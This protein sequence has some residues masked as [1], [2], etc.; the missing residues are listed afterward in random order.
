MDLIVLGTRNEGKAAEL[1]ILLRGV[2]ARL[3][4]LREHPDVKLP[5]ET[6]ATY[7]E[8]AI[9]KARAVHDALRVPALGD[10]SG[11]EVDALEGAPGLYSARYAGPDATDHAN[12]EKLLQALTGLP[13]AKRTARFRCVLALVA[14]SEAPR[15][16]EG[17][18]E[19]RI[20]EA[21]R[22]RDGF[23]YDPVFQPDGETVSFA[24]LEPERKNQI[25][26]RARAAR[27]LLRNLGLDR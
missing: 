17:S 6:G 11:L 3:E 12:N 20:L 5:P 23:G 25:S 8:N 18:C 7:R 26:H 27:E 15:V 1:R 9:A 10:D 2:A 22:G 14:G 19:G 4:S 16:F 24:E 13:A 21:P